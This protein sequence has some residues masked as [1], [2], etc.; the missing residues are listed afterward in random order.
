MSHE[1][2]TIILER[3][4]DT[5]TTLNDL[6][7]EHTSHPAGLDDQIEVYINAIKKAVDDNDLERLNAVTANAQ[8]LIGRINHDKAVEHFHNY[9]ILEVDVDEIY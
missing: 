4:G 8:A 5:L 1:S 7:D 3:A 6:A 2:N 9:D